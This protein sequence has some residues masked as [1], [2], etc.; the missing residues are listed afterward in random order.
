MASGT[1][2]ATLRPAKP[3]CIWTWMSCSTRR[4]L[5]ASVSMANLIFDGGLDVS[6]GQRSWVF[7][8][9]GKNVWQNWNLDELGVFL[10]DFFWTFWHWQFV[11]NF[12]ILV[13]F[14]NKTWNIM[15]PICGIN[16][17]FLGVMGSNDSRSY[18]KGSTPCILHM[19]WANG[20]SHTSQGDGLWIVTGTVAIL[21]PR[22]TLA[23]L[24][25]VSQFW[26]LLFFA[27]HW[28]AAKKTTVSTMRLQSDHFCLQLCFVVLGKCS[29]S[30]SLVAYFDLSLG[31][32]DIAYYF[33]EGD[34][35]QFQ[36]GFTR[37]RFKNRTLC[38]LGQ[39][40]INHSAL[41][42]DVRSVEVKLLKSK[43]TKSLQLKDP[44]RGFPNSQAIPALAWLSSIWNSQ[45]CFL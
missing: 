14:S 2:T 1:V 13:E 5:E 32:N 6:W 44:S 22:F 3:S 37:E 25:C 29:H 38:H 45:N 43:W 9:I 33:W 7:L 27:H 36:N 21:I 41:S 42:S 24:S 34:A 23:D 15:E 16:L 30:P 35:I 28:A 19:A 31:R 12:I 8:K 4:R 17:L 18:S 40:L 26:M 39:W 20:L 10:W 11:G